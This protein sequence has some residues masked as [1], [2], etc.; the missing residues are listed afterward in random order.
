MTADAALPWL[1][2]PLQS[3]ARLRGHATLLHGPGGCGEFE[4]AMAIAQQWLCEDAQRQPAY[5]PCGRCTSCRAVLARSH[6]DLLL[7]VPEA[8]RESLGLA[9]DADEAE[10]GEGRSKAKPSRELK[11]QALRGA[12]D[13]AH[14]TSSRGGLKVLLIHPA[15]AMN[16]VSANAL[17]KTLEEPPGALRLLLTSA[18]PQRLL[19]TVRS[20]C[21]RFQ[22]DLPAAD[23]AQA[24]LQG[25]GVAQAD[26]SALLA[27]SGGRPQEALALAREGLGERAWRALPAAVRRGD[28]SVVAGWPLPRLVETLSKLCHDLM[29]QAAGGSPRYF[30]AASLPPG[31][32][33]PALAAWSRLLMQAARQADHPWH[34]G[35]Y[36]EALFTQSAQ[37]WRPGGEASLATLVVP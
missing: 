12:I 9:G 10:P 22:L 30:D 37:V 3:A 1:D 23:A 20:R 7:L 17:L 29:A 11:V 27:A 4:L 21:Q 25:Q 26:A 35:L 34:A 16:A 6:P 32:Q 8:L 31:A 13:W 15:D 18:D 36:A 14:Q 28:A 33:W 2:A 24:W 5:R 19:P